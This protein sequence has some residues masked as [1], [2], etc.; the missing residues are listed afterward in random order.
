MSKYHI[1]F[2]GTGGRSVHYARHYAARDDMEIVALADPLPHNRKV[3]SGLVDIDG[4]AE[5]FD[6]WHAMYQHRDDLDAVV[7]CSPNHV[8]AEQAIPFLERGLPIVLEKSIAITPEDCDRLLAAAD[9]AKRE[10]EMLS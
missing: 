2:I 4:K 5:E 7:I 6:D 1:G 8:H 10:T 3:F 9:R